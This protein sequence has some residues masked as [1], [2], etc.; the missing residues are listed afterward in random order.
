[1]AVGGGGGGGRRWQAPPWLSAAGQ[2]PSPRRGRP[3]SA[4]RTPRGRR[5]HP[6]H[7]RALSPK[8]CCQSLAARPLPRRRHHNRCG[9][10]TA[11]GAGVRRVHH[12]GGSRRQAPA[13]YSTLPHTPLRRRLVGPAPRWRWC[14]PHR[15][16]VSTVVAVPGGHSVGK[17]RKPSAGLPPT[18][19]R[20]QREHRVG[21]EGAPP[22]GCRPLPPSMQYNYS[23]SALAD[24][25]DP[26]PAHAHTRGAVKIA[27]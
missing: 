8:R 1:M 19:P 7:G 20:G 23:L 4:G 9:G 26:S 24:D 25:A 3:A 5:R 11:A 16:S 14:R 15:S 17:C 2:R 13:L 6:G 21:A 27:A 22:A 10:T 18:P 12:R